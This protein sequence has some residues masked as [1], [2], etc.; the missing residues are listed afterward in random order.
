MFAPPP[1]NNHYPS[2]SESGDSLSDSFLDA[3]VAQGAINNLNGPIMARGLGPGSPNY[4][5]AFD[6]DVALFDRPNDPTIREMF[7]SQ[8]Y[9][10]QALVPRV[11]YFQPERHS[12][13]QFRTRS[14][15]LGSGD[16]QY[17]SRP[18]HHIQTTMPLLPQLITENL[19]F[20]AD[21]PTV[22]DSNTGCAPEPN[23]TTTTSSCG[24]SPHRE[25]KQWSSEATQDD[26]PPRVRKARREKPRIQ[27]APDQPPTT[28]GKARSRVYVA[29]VQWYVN[30]KRF[31]SSDQVFIGSSSVNMRVVE[32][33]KFA[34]MVP[35]RRVTTAVVERRVVETHARM[36][37][38]P[39]G[40]DLIRLPERVSGPQGV[41][42]KREMSM[43]LQSDVDAG[44]VSHRRHRRAVTKLQ[45]DSA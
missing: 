8:P 42:A 37:Q 21:T 32:L 22:M 29:C 14:L 3:E 20:A 41:V 18:K 44:N 36:I 28:Q 10:D 15:H 19:D 40:V 23:S 25:S 30:L 1:V 17:T 33:E 34:A 13:T 16:A 12:P 27:L 7:I 4:L 24:N 43:A 9:D 2:S 31:Y 35:N 39:S 5:S 45:V 6:Q 26:H 38:R 11:D